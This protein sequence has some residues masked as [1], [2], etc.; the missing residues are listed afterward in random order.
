MFRTFLSRIGPV[1]ALAASILAM[2][3][4][5]AQATYPA[6]PINLVVPYAAGGG[7]DI[8]V[9][10][11]ARRMAQDL[12][13]SVVIHNVAGGGA[14]IGARQVA[15]AA[16]DGY[17]VLVAVAANIITNPILTKDPGY[18]PI[19]D[20]APITLLSTN[21]MI[22]VAA[23]GSGMRTLADVVARA[24][25]SPGKLSIASYGSGTPSHLAIELLQTVAGIDVIHV[26]YKGAAPAMVDVLGG[27]IPLMMDFLPGQ[28]QT[29][30]NG[31]VVGLAVG[32]KQRSPL[33]P[34]VPTFGEAGLSEFEALTWFGL[35]APAGTPAHAIDRLNKAAR[36]ALADPGVQADLRKQG[37]T[38]QP[39]SPQEMSAF[40]KS[41]Y[42][43]WETVIRRANI[44][45]R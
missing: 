17:H 34:D 10:V 36:E 9:R 45:Q 29:L 1:F 8:A 24:K 43:K 21:P 22:L 7:T 40:F 28:I 25:A 42:E 33:A 37:M 12:G 20:F 19:K 2:G 30:A 6:G 3:S 5:Q 23:K 16:P 15:R 27:H 38:V 14:M 11:I 44:A 32:Q 31:D 18:D 41:E 39:T 13:Q 35:V 26:P 4:A